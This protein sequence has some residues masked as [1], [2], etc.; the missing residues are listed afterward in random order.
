MHYILML[1]AAYGICFGLMND[2]AKISTDL[3]KSIPVFKDKEGKTFFERMFVCPYCTGFH[4]GWAVWLAV[5]WEDLIEATNAEMVEFAVST[6]VF[7]FASS[8]FCYLVD[9]FAQWLEREG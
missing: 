5:K 4:S 3:L 1:G 9:T 6:L 2:K 7:A 8:V